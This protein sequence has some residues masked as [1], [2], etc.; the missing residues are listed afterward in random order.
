MTSILLF[1]LVSLSACVETPGAQEAAAT[2]FLKSLGYEVVGV[3]C[4]DRDSDND[5]YVSCTGRVMGAV[6]G[7]VGRVAEW[8]RQ[9]KP[10]STAGGES[11]EVY[12]VG[13]ERKRREKA[14]NEIMCGLAAETKARDEV[15]AELKTRFVEQVMEAL[16]E[17]R[18]RWRAALVFIAEHG[19][20]NHETECGTIACNGSWCAEQARASLQNVEIRDARRITPD[21]E[22]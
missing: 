8:W 9:R 21:V 6:R 16:D 3:A 14:L 22:R 20:H 5:G 7:A 12:F 2:A 15:I 11:H 19:G 18:N 17:D 10:F 4:T 1:V 13:D